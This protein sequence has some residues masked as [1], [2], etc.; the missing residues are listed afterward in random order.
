[1]AGCL[2]SLSRK[3]SSIRPKISSAV[4]T[5]TL[6][7]IV[8]IQLFCSA[9]KSVSFH[10][11]CHWLT[12]HNLSSH[13]MLQMGM[14]YAGSVSC[15][16]SILAAMMLPNG[17]VSNLLWTVPQSVTDGIGWIW[18]CSAIIQVLMG[19]GLVLIPIMMCLWITE[20]ISP[21]ACISQCYRSLQSRIAH[22]LTTAM[23]ESSPWTPCLFGHWAVLWIVLNPSQLRMW[24]ISQID[25]LRSNRKPQLSRMSPIASKQ[26]LSKCRQLSKRIFDLSC[27]KTIVPLAWLR[28]LKTNAKLWPS[29]WTSSDF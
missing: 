21:G 1:M 17:I 9:V 13:S 16:L 12:R 18:H 10:S 23:T 19:I 3:T 14:H 22:A 27:A 2:L 29:I 26:P 24:M 11:V 28:M 4:L 20:K 8:W 5:S 25:L 6:V 7:S 15:C